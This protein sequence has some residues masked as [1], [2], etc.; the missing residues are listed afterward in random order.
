MSVG[1]ISEQEDEDRETERQAAA[2]K[3]QLSKDVASWSNKR[4]EQPPEHAIAPR[5]PTRER[6]PAQPDGRTTK[7]GAAKAP[8]NKPADGRSKP[9]SM[10]YGGMTYAQYLQYTR[11]RGSR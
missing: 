7:P 6:A 2:M 11:D 10:S 9:F 5:R 4:G 8:G 3:A 1:P